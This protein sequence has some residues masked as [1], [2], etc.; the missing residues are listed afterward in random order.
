MHSV[1]IIDES[2]NSLLTATM[3]PTIPR[4]GEEIILEYGIERRFY[5]VTKVLHRPIPP[6]IWTV[7]VT[8]KLIGE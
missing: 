3:S 5:T 4:V 2:G 6:N 7:L 1:Q 8:C